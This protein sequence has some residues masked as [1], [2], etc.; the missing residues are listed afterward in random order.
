MEELLVIS[1]IHF[2]MSFRHTLMNWVWQLTREG[3]QVC[4]MHMPIAV[5][6]RHLQDIISEHLSA[7]IKESGE[8]VAIPSL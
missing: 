7:K 6:I 4:C 8:H 2:G 3:I 1:L 5:S